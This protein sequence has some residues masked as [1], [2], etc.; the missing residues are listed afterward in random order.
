MHLG[1]VVIYILMQ[2]GGEKTAWLMHAHR[3]LR[4]EASFVAGSSSSGASC[5]I[6]IYIPLCYDFVIFVV[7]VSL[8]SG[9][10]LATPMG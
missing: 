6:Y 9:D 8:C 3:G 1:G 4:V 7:V 5:K 2:G 10:S